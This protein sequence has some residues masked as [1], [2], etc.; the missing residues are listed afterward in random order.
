MSLQVFFASKTSLQRPEVVGLGHFDPGSS[1]RSVHLEVPRVATRGTLA[2]NGLDGVWVVLV[3]G[4]YKPLI[5]INMVEQYGSVLLS[6]CFS[7]IYHTQFYP[8]RR[9]RCLGREDPC[10]SPVWGRWRVKCVQKSR[11]NSPSNRSR[12]TSC[13]SP[14]SLTGASWTCVLVTES[15]RSTGSTVSIGWWRNCEMAVR[16]TSK[17]TVIDASDA[18]ATLRALTQHLSDLVWLRNYQ[19]ACKS[20]WI[21]PIWYMHWYDMACCGMICRRSMQLKSHVMSCHVMSCHVYWYTKV[22]WLI[23]GSVLLSLVYI[24]VMSCFSLRVICT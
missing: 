4:W 5:S 2:R 24:S 22:S 8:L 10:L 13:S 12:G 23:Y 17:F 19:K 7:N 9:S 14:R 16:F 3:Y 20:T 18:R 21:N 11:S 1:Q 6:L 15:C